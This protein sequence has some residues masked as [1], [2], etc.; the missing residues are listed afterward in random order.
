MDAEIEG[1]HEYVAEMQR[2]LLPERF[3][4]MVSAQVRNL[5]ATIE[6][7][8][9][10]C[11]KDEA[12]ALLEKIRGCETW[13]AAQVHSL[14]T[15][16]DVAVQHNERGNSC[17]DRKPQVCPNVEVFW[18]DQMW[19]Q[20]LDD[21]K[22]RHARIRF[23]VD[24]LISMDLTAPDE[25]CKQRLVAMLSLGDAWIREDAK[26][27]KQTQDELTKALRKHRPPTRLLR[28][29]HFVNFPASAFDACEL[30]EGF[31]ERVYGPNGHPSDEPPYDSKDIDAAVAGA[32]T[33]TCELSLSQTTI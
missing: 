28:R 32:F 21:R 31:E 25:R 9:G 3:Q 18:S 30:L 29:P 13:S 23:I 15:S 6:N 16:L 5:K 14:S 19:D 4:V 22:P 33:G 11:T 27:A 1:V 10:G 12:L 8:E 20:T 26:N 24:T 17:L 2:N 7:Y